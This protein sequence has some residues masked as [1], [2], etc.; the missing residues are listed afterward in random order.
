M[1]SSLDEV[2][3]MEIGSDTDA[4]KTA[5]NGGVLIDIPIHPQLRLVLDA[6]PKDTF[7]FLETRHGKSRSP[8]GLGNMMR[9]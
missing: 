2:M 7:T 4:K 8:N 6:L 9:K 1:W 5:D 3:S